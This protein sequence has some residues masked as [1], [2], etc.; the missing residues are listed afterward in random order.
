MSVSQTRVCETRTV[1][2]GLC[3]V[4]TPHYRAFERDCG[5]AGKVGWADTDNE[6]AIDRRGVM[7]GHGWFMCDCE[8][9]H[10]NQPGRNVAPAQC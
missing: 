7:P 6:E 8:G 3:L 4:E 5:T 9:G 10:L 2:V 1:D